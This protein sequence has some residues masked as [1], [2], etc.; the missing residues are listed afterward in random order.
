VKAQELVETETELG[1]AVTAR[2]RSEDLDIAEWTPLGDLCATHP[3]VS[4]FV[5]LRSADPTGQEHLRGVR[6]AL[7]SYSLHA[8]RFRGITCPDEEYAVVWLVHAGVHRSQDRSDPY[9]AAV[10]LNDRGRLMPTE[11]DYRRLF[12]RRN[13]L[14]VPMLVSRLTA[15]LAEARSRQNA[16]QSVLL[17]G[18]VTV[19]LCVTVEPMDDDYGQVEAIWLSVQKRGLQSGWLEVILATLSVDGR[20]DRPW[21]QTPEFPGRGHDR[22]ELRFR[23][24]QETAEA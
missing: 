1:L 6:F 9:R 10:A 23:F 3:V 20:D 12:E 4:K 5:E 22:T 13:E 14:A 2:C 19:S 15:T 8:G 7:P 18:G 24:W 16:H 17:P 11:D 21:H